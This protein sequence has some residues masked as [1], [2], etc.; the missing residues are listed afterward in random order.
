[1]KRLSRVNNLRLGIILSVTGIL[2]I[3]AALFRSTHD[4]SVPVT[5]AIGI[6]LLVASAPFLTRA[7]QHTKGNN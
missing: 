7:L 6:V 2:A 1:M 4:F 3:A 5:I